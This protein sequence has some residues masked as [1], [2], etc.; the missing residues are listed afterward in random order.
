MEKQCRR[1]NKTKPLSEY[2]KHKQMRDGHI[3][4]CRDCRSTY[5]YGWKNENRQVVK[6]KKAKY[7]FERKDDINKLRREDRKANPSKYKEQNLRYFYGITISDYNKMLDEQKG[8]CRICKNPELSK[9]K[10]GKIRDLAVDHDHKTKKIRGLLCSM[11][12]MGLGK[13]RENTEYLKGAIEYIKNHSG[14]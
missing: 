10:N 6:T 5:C 2:H 1:C 4:V 3:N 14:E 13:F 11:C 8:V 7:H 9:H 12:N